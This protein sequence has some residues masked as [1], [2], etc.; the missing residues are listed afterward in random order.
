[1]WRRQKQVWL[2]VGTGSAVCAGLR[3][4]IA[5]SNRVARRVD[6]GTGRSPTDEGEVCPGWV[7]GLG[8]GESLELG[9]AQ[10]G[11]GIA[12]GLSEPVVVEALH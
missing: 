5:A 2:S 11:G 10:G 8:C 12:L 6:R 7:M 4:P 1:M 9:S 3:V